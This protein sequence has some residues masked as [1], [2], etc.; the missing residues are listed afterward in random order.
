MSKSKAG[1]DQFMKDFGGP[2][3]DDYMSKKEPAVYRSGNYS[4]T[5]YAKDAMEHNK[6]V[7]KDHF[8]KKKAIKETCLAILSVIDDI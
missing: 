1:K 2:D 5:K 4:S 7:L 6:K 3:G 8:A